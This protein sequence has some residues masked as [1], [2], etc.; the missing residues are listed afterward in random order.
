MRRLI[1][2]HGGE[3]VKYL[4][5]MSVVMVAAATIVYLLHQK[6][7]QI[8]QY[9]KSIPTL[10]IRTLASESV[11]RCVWVNEGVEDV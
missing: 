11:V 6:V 7:A 1:V 9:V 8:K 3:L 10:F 4:S 5:T 2:A